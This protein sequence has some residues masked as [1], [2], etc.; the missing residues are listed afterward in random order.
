M[1]DVIARYTAGGCVG[2]QPRQDSH[3]RETPRVGTGMGEP[4]FGSMMCKPNVFPR[5]RRDK[6]TGRLV[7]VVVAGRTVDA[8]GIWQEANE[9]YEE[10][11][12]EAEQGASGGAGRG[13]AEMTSWGNC[14]IKA[15]GKGWERDAE[16]RLSLIRNDDMAPYPCANDRKQ[17]MMCFVLC[18]FLAVSRRTCGIFLR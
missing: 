3:P 2:A 9:I 13:P 16:G 4:P 7:G 5:K 8:E 10:S 12:P 1:R 18:C 6:V 14:E 11:C 17:E 15:I